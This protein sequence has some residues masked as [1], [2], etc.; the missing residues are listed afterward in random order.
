[1]LLG[2]SQAGRTL[3]VTVSVAVTVPT[4]ASTVSVPVVAGA[5]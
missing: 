5:V 3:E 4:V 2:L 1:M